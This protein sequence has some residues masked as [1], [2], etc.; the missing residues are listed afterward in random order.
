MVGIEALVAI[1]LIA[2]GA[3]L[4]VFALWGEQRIRERMMFGRRGS[5]IAGA[6]L[7]GA[8]IVLAVIQT[9]QRGV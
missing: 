9:L 2:G 6:L 5:V 7:A 8:G 1:L 3:G 4:I